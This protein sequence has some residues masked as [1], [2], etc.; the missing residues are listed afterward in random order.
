MSP[1]RIPRGVSTGFL[2]AHLC[3][4]I[5][6]AREKERQRERETERQRE[7]ERQRESEREGP[8]RERACVYSW[9]MF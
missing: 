2:A 8:K 6:L 3:P 9:H 4:T 7:R 1:L 5:Q